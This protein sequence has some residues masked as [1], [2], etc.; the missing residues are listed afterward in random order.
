MADFDDDRYLD[1]LQ[2]IEASIVDVYRAEPDLLD[3]DVERALYGVIVALNAERLGKPFDLE[4]VKLSEHGER[5]F[6]AVLAVAEWRI[7]GRPLA[8]ERTGPL[9]RSVEELVAC[10]Q[11]VRKSVQR[12]TKERGRRGYLDFVKAYLP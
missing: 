1:V 3:S 9:P 10:L 11:R 4:K 5:V 2:N 12:W 6:Q 7:T 8:G